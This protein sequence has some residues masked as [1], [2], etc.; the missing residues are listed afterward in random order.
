[1]GT[2]DIQINGL[3][4]IKTS[5]IRRSILRMIIPII[6]EGVL[7]ML[8]SFISMAMTGKL[9]ATSIAGL[10]LSVRIT[11]IIWAFFKGIA[12]GATI[13]IAQAYGANDRKKLKGITIQTL[14]S[15][16]I[17]VI[18][19]QQILF[20]FAPKIVTLIFSA[21]G[22]LLDTTVTH[23]RAVSFGLPFLVIMLV[24]AG[25]MQATGDA[26]TPLIVAV[27]MNVVNV[28]FSYLFIF[29][30]LGINGMGVK[31]AAIG[32]AISQLVSAI[33]YLYIFFRKKGLIG[34][35]NKSHFKLD[36]NQIKQIYKVSLPSSMEAVFLQIAVIIVTNVVLGY[37]ENHLAAYQLAVQAE[38]MFFTP[39]MGFGV[40]ATAFI[41]QSLGSKNIKLAKAYMKEICIET[42]LVTSIAVIALVFFPN[43][44]MGLL[45]DKVELIEIGVIYLIVTGLIQIP[46]NIGTVIVGAIRGAGY[47]KAPMI[48]S[49]IGI[50]GVR[51]LGAVVIGSVLKLDIIW[52]WIAIDIDLLVRLII[53][54][55]MYKK[56]NIYEN[57]IIL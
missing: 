53:S 52:I 7:Q 5:R 55:V 25:I 13:F 43:V 31:G 1:M 56:K 45:T 16:I 37:G 23:L 51:V 30:G 21:E 42:L 54:Y 33:L 34:K 29:G 50:W 24:A 32:L 26:L 10:G 38:G 20:W 44:L 47:S 40:A 17:I 3:D 9:D 19:I 11:Q 4:D 57:A 49:A 8:A 6:L 22:A 15:S 48:I 36:M 35:V 27:V 28:I 41:G 18:G 2:A 39:A 46:Q 12:M 14:I